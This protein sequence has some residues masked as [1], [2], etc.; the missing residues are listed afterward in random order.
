M[1]PCSTLA[2]QIP[3][4]W[5][6]GRCHPVASAGPEATT[7]YHTHTTFCFVLLIGELMCPQLVT[8]DE[9]SVRPDTP[10]DCYQPFFFDRGMAM[11]ALARWRGLLPN[12]VLGVLVLGEMEPFPNRNVT[13]CRR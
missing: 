2:S 3:Q 11:A 12:L 9:E 6:S 10:K 5:A 13:A 8:N 4:R 1:R 7:L